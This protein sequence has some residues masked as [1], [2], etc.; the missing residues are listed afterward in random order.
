MLRT[1]HTRRSPSTPRSFSR[2]RPRAAPRGR[3]RASPLTLYLGA[4]SDHSHQTPHCPSVFRTQPPRSLPF[5]LQ[6]GAQPPSSWASVS[7]SA[8]TLQRGP[9][10]AG[11][12]RIRA[13]HQVCVRTPRH[14]TH[15]CVSSRVC[16]APHR[17]RLSRSSPRPTARRPPPAARQTQSG[18]R[19][20]VQPRRRPLRSAV[21]S[22]TGLSSARGTPPSQQ[23]RFSN[24]PGRS[25]DSAHLTSYP[26][27][28]GQTPL[29]P[30][31]AAPRPAPRFYARAPSLCCRRR[32]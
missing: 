18:Y 4:K 22:R 10:R 1:P 29:A 32:A 11:E 20:D 17:V 12:L 7:M 28:P 2:S 6:P 5:R 14:I 23:V 31:T 24:A 13:A 16:P 21:T 25:P 27:V 8:G 15:S 3:Y 19:E 9:R 30:S 26:L